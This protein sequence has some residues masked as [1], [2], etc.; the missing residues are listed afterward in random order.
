MTSSES[1][2]IMFLLCVIEA[3]APPTTKCKLYTP[4]PEDAIKGSLATWSCDI[5]E[6]EVIEIKSREENSE[7][8]STKIVNGEETKEKKAE[9]EAD[10]KTEVSNGSDSST[11]NNKTPAQNLKPV[12]DGKTS[13]IVALPVTRPKRSPC[14]GRSKKNCKGK[15]RPKNS[16]KRNSRRR[17]AAKAQRKRRH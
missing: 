15:R 16:K 14:N 6:R 2:S 4:T 13:K 9:K 12:E 10:R 8:N 1:V 11:K 7:G 5:S 3:A 17:R